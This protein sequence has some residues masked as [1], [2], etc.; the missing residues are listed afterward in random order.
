ME[1]AE[2]RPFGHGTQRRSAAVIRGQKLDDVGDSG[3]GVH[4][5]LPRSQALMLAA[6]WPR[7]HPELAAVKSAGWLRY[8]DRP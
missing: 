6:S 1:G 5:G 2:S 8:T 3:V 7:R 4:L